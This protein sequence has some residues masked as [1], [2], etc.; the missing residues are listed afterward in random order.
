MSASGSD[1][2]RRIAFGAVGIA[3][4]AAFVSLVISFFVEMLYVHAAFM[5]APSTPSPADGYVFPLNQHG[6][7]HYLRYGPHLADMIAGDIAVVCIPF[8]I[9]VIALTKAH[10]VGKD[11]HLP[12]KT[13]DKA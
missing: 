6:V 2:V 11:R 4:V 1:R 10:D 12:A 8:L 5:H 9:V 13:H 3:A 7:I